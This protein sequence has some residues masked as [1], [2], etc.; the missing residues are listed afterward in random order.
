M[1]LEFCRQIFEKYTSNFIKIWP[2]GP[3]SMWKNGRTGGG[4]TDMTKLIIAFRNFSKT[5]KKTFISHTVYISLEH[6]SR[7]LTKGTE[8]LSHGH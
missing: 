6:I 7:Q 3:S 4:Q 1:K 2:V 8:F 5:P